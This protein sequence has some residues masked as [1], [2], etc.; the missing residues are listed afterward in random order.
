MATAHP[1]AMGRSDAWVTCAATTL[2]GRKCE[3]AHCMRT[4]STGSVL[5]DSQTSW[6]QR[7]DPRSTRPPP[8]AHSISVCSGWRSATAAIRSQVART[9][10]TQ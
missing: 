10:S 1:K 7:S 4:R 2:A 6:N 9:W 5:S 3:A 8:D